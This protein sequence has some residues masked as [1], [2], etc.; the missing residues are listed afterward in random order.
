M[1]ETF[2][3]ILLLKSKGASDERGSFRKFF[4]ESLLE[5]VSFE[6]KQIN[7]VE[8]KAAH[9]LRG[10]HYQTGD[11][12]EGKIF[13]VLNGSIQLG[14]F[15]TTSE[16]S[17]SLILDDVDKAYYVPRG[18]ATGY[19]TLSRNTTVFYMSDNSYAPSHESGLRPNDPIL[20]IDWL[21]KTYHQSEKDKSWPNWK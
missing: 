16:K 9:T 2:D 21:N 14:F 19:L 4:D 12:A 18:Y 17:G 1:P 6:I 15:D 5:S 7:H 20:R 8:T 3:D 13:R 11:H 10:L